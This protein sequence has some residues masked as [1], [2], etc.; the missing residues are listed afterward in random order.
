MI[1]MMMMMMML[2]MYVFNDYDDT[3][4]VLMLYIRTSSH[5]QVA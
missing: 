4:F 5:P 3:L 1:M 2:M